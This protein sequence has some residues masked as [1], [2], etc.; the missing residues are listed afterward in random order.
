RCAAP[1]GGP[2]GTGAV[3]A[4]LDPAGTS[5][6]VVSDQGVRAQLVVP[7]GAVADPIAVTVTPRKPGLGQG[8]NLEVSPGGG[9]FRVPGTLTITLPPGVE[10][11]AG[12][13]SVADPDGKPSY[14]TA[15]TLD[16]AARTLTTTLSFLGNPGSRPVPG[17][18][19][20]RS[21]FARTTCPGGGAPQASSAD[22]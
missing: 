7:P 10:P 8:L 14:P 19:A 1:G 20:R 11:G 3:A 17:T 2:A 4:T 16:A 6:E 18:D 22:Y 13:V 21:A 9:I 5:V 12:L 15:T